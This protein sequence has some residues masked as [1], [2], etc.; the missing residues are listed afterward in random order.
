MTQVY[1]S[2]DSLPSGGPARPA[3][4]AFGSFDGLHR[5]H[6]ALVARV[7]E[8]ARRLG[9]QSL[10]LS[11]SNHPLGILAPPYC[12]KLLLDPG[13]KIELLT[14]L[15]VDA[16][17]LPEFTRELSQMPPR[18]FV[19]ELLVERLGMR[20]IVSGYDCR[21][22]LGGKGGSELLKEMGGELGFEVEILPPLMDQDVVISSRLVRALIAMG[23]VER[24]AEFLERPHEL[25]G[26]VVAGDQRGRT[27]GFP[28][29]NL[30]FSEE[31]QLPAYG[32]YAIWADVRGH[33]YG[34][35][36]NIGAN[37][38]FD[39]STLSPEAHLF[40]FEGDIYGESMTVYFLRMLRKELRFP[41]AEALRRQLDLDR[42]TALEA[43]RHFG[44]RDADPAPPEDK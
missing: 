21:F 36:M 14:E 27:L 17:V 41:S 24:A 15:G 42:Q 31:F 30:R 33:R 11:F 5:A 13:R 19:R 39:Q 18:R 32:V 26:K 25:T 4:L 43:L 3:A 7:R 6:R 40:D 2:L 12:P 9:A 23:D 29:A 16:I 38:T 20:H 37:P 34:G 44:E 35:M 22:G 10:V 8:R 28:T 1:R